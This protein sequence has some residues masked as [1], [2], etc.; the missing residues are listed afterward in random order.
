MSSE[1]IIPRVPAVPATNR[2]KSGKTWWLVPIHPAPETSRGRSSQ[3]PPHAQSL[4]ERGTFHNAPNRPRLC[5]PRAV[6]CESRCWCH[7]GQ[8]SAS[9]C[10]SHQHHEAHPKKHSRDAPQPRDPEKRT[11]LQS[12][13]FGVRVHI[14]HG[15]P[16]QIEAHRTQFSPMAAAVR[17][18]TFTSSMF[19]TQR[20]GGQAVSVHATLRPPS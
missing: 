11:C 4:P 15:C 13:G 12:R 6:L 5:R 20:M 10:P 9:H 16:I 1:T 2:A 14:C 19:P 18:V 17:R 3:S 7:H 8:E